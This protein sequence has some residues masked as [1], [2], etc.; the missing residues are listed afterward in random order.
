MIYD[1]ELYVLLCCSL[2]ALGLCIV[3][4]EGNFKSKYIIIS[5]ANGSKDRKWLVIY[6]VELCVL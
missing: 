4:C 1:V 2:L 6:D 3:F 5:F